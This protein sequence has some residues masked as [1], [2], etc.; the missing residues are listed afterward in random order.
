MRRVLLCLLIAFACGN[1]VARE[2]KLSSPGGESCDASLPAPKAAAKKPAA[3]VRNN[4]AAEARVRP[5]VHGDANI[6]PR[7]RWH[8]FLPGMFR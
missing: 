6:A 7:M 4:A 8:S 5:T 1:V 3:R 2:V